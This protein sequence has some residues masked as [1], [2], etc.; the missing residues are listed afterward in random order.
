MSVANNVIYPNF[1]GNSCGN[2]ICDNPMKL[3]GN[4]NNITNN[5]NFT[6]PPPTYEFPQCPIT[7][8]DFN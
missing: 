3:Y 2:P 5:N 4:D 1:N 8:K 6:T 7:L